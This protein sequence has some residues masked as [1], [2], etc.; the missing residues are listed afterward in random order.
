M[1]RSHTIDIAAP[2]ERVWDVLTDVESWSAWTSTVTS[3]HRLDEGP[4][5][6]GSRAKIQQPRV[7]GPGIQPP[8][9]ERAARRAAAPRCGPPNRRRSFPDAAW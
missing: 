3:V 8:H 5:R 7:P 1:E 2:S 4:L 9:H 6:L